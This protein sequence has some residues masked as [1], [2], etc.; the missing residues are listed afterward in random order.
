VPFAHLAARAEISRLFSKYDSDGD[1]KV[2][3]L[4]FKRFY[5]NVWDTTSKMAPQAK[6]KDYQPAASAASRAAT[7]AEMED[8]YR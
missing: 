3:L 8:Q 2:D 1:S 4:E 6:L 7:A 5:R